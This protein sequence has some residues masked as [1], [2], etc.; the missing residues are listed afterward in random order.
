MSLLKDYLN[1]K[2]VVITTEGY[3]LEGKMI[4]FDKHCN[5]GLENCKTR[6]TQTDNPIK[7]DENNN[8]PQVKLL[9]GSEVVCVGLVDEELEKTEVA[10][11]LKK[12]Q[13]E[14]H[15]IILE[16]L[17]DTKNKPANRFEILKKVSEHKSKK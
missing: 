13:Q 12:S 3:T 8:G 17:N 15:D 5:L 2:V 11:Y 16:K 4:S 1:Q 6:F 9:R 10:K 14:G 7:E